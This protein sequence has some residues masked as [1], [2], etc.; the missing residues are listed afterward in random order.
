MVQKL[1]F[2]VVVATTA[3]PSGSAMSST[4]ILW[5]SPYNMSYQ[6]I[7]LVGRSNQVDQF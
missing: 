2:M 4:R 1:A 7:D 5:T 6:N 3:S